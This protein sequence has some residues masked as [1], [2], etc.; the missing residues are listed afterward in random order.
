M[1]Q[2]VYIFLGTGDCNRR[3]VL[4]DLIREGSS[5]SS[6]L[7]ISADERIPEKESVFA[8]NSDLKLASWHFSSGLDIEIDD[9]D[10]T[11]DNIFWLLDSKKDLIDQLEAVMLL[12]RQKDWEVERVVTFVDCKFASLVPESADWFKA[13][14]YFSDVVLLANRSNVNNDWVKHF[15]ANYKN[16]FYP[17]AFELVKK[18]KVDNPLRVLDGEPRRLTMIFDDVDPID[19]MEFDEDN[20]PEEPFDLVR[21]EDPYFEKTDAGVRKLQLPNLGD[22]LAKYESLKNK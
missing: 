22:L 6:I 3:L 20:L 18:D 17:C 5:G 4:D 9:F 11:A 21:K 2:K 8:A 19:D 13:C 16:A 1:S 12:S 10:F 14:I 15:E 7:C